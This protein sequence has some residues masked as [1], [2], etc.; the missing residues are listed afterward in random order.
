MSAPR[1]LC[2]DDEPA[3]LEGAGRVLQPDFDVTLAAN[4]SQALEL[5][6]GQP[7]FAVV[8]SD[9]EMPG[10]DGVALLAEIRER[11]PDTTRVLMTGKADLDTAIASINEGQIFRFLTKPCAP[12]ALLA[13]ARTALRQHQLVTSERVLLEQ[14]LNGSVR[15]LT[16]VLALAS[17]LAFGRAGKL[18]RLVAQLAAKMGEREVWRFEMAAMLS[19]IGAITLPARTA[20]KVYQGKPLDPE[21]Q[22]QVDEMPALADSWLRNIPRLEDVCASIRQQ[23]QHFDGGVGWGRRA[24]EIPMG[25]RLLKVAGDY[26]VLLSQGSSPAAAIETMRSRSGWY[27]PRLL[28]ALAAQC[29]SRGGELTQEIALGEA[30]PGMILGEDIR[31]QEGGLLMAK[32]FALS[33]SLLHRLKHLGPGTLREAVRVVV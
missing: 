25:A 29:G 5:A 11:S 28:V 23:E 26:D 12:A 7:P 6:G 22:A 9:K 1:L 8:I 21:E 15:A 31:A 30:L 18:K 14:T 16:D 4:A 20:E 32:G 27:D 13:C 33:E 24:E 19:Q 3:I 2:V 17:P 10:M